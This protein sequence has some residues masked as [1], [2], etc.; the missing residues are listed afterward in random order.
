MIEEILKDIGFPAFIA[1]ILLYDKLKSNANLKQTVENNTE[2]LKRIE[3][4]LR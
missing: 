2:I 3:V 1:A 4:R